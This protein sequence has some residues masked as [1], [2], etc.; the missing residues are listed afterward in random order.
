MRAPEVVC[1]HAGAAWTAPVR[2][3]GR[4][5]SLQDP[6]ANAIRVDVVPRSPADS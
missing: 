4:T 3:D 1:E 5:V 6:W 2:D